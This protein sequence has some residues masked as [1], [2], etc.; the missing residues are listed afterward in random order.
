MRCT[1]IRAGLANQYL[2]ST[3]N[4]VCLAVRR[5]VWQR[6]H[7]DGF[8]QAGYINDLGVIPRGSQ[9]LIA[10]AVGTTTGA[11]LGT[12]T[13]TTYI[14]S[15]SGVSVGGRRGFTF[16]IPQR[17]RATCAARTRLRLRDRTTPEISS[18]G[19]PWVVCDR[20]LFYSPDRRHSAF[21]HS[22]R[23]GN[24]GVLMAGRCAMRSANSARRVHR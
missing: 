15:A 13:V 16:D 5:S 9:A 21:C 3:S 19:C 18:R 2:R 14:E 4:Y 6:G 22:T 17:G 8:V 11:F 23:P 7:P 20:H 10:D 12:S 24:V 1:R